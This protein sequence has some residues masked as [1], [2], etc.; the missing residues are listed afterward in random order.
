MSNS[1]AFVEYLWVPTALVHGYD[2]ARPQ[3]LWCLPVGTGGPHWHQVLA[4]ARS[5]TGAGAERAP[6]GRRAAG[7]HCAPRRDLGHGVLVGAGFVC[8]TAITAWC[9]YC[10]GLG[11]FWAGWTT[12][13]EALTGEDLALYDDDGSGVDA[14]Q[15][16]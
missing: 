6:G 1:A 9:W 13:S 3:R 15:A 10:A 4:D 11:L 8:I 12:T 5:C 14:R 16:L 7:L 2:V